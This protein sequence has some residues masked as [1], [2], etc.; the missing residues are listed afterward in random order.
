MAFQRQEM[1]NQIQQEH[2]SAWGKLKLGLGGNLSQ[3]ALPIAVFEQKTKRDAGIALVETKVEHLVEHLVR[4]IKADIGVKSRHL[5][6]HT[7]R[8]L[9]QTMAGEVSQNIPEATKTALL[10][11]RQYIDSLS[12]QYVA[13]LQ[14]KVA[15]L[16]DEVN[17]KQ[18]EAT[19]LMHS[20]SLAGRLGKQLKTKIQARVQEVQAMQSALAAQKATIETI[21]GNVGEYVHRSYRAFDDPEWALKVPDTVLNK[22]REHVQ[23]RY[24]AQGLT[25]A[26]ANK[27]TEVVLQE[28]LKH[29]TAYESMQGLIH[30][31]KLGA[32][33][34]SVLMHRKKIA[35]PIRD[36]LGEYVDPRVAFA[37]TAT[38]M[39]RLIFNHSFL[40]RVKDAGMGQ[41]LWTEAEKPPE[42]TVK[43][44]ADKSEVY[45][46]LN[47]LWTTPE[48]NQAF[49][50]AL[51]KEQ[52]ANL[53]Q[54]IFQ[55]I[56]MIKSDQASLFSATY[57]QFIISVT[58]TA[59]AWRLF[60][61]IHW[62]PNVDWATT[63]LHCLGITSVGGLILFLP[64]PKIE[65]SEENERNLAT[66]GGIEG[67]GLIKKNRVKW[68]LSPWLFP[69]LLIF[70]VGLHTGFEYM[71]KTEK[72][73]MVFADSKSGL[74][75]W[76]GRNGG[77]SCD[78]SIIREFKKRGTIH[79]GNRWEAERDGFRPAYECPN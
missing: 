78:E 15:Q 30:E 3:G 65:L 50:D 61:P 26:E 24:T 31:S 56:G 34:L 43:I 70:G 55:L 41:F 9:S 74:Y 40:D 59:I 47:G 25:A 49:K 23:E 19:R 52:M 63:I 69:L 51:G 22:A 4:S 73:H 35:Q 18:R 76:Y 54:S 11:M 57:F 28:I 20:E 1:N 17:R 8:L 67:L 68:L 71:E 58:L 75:V 36:L 53:Y 79:Y 5:E 38:K 45:S 42:A 64:I 37:K 72:Y 39:G 12:A 27:R 62:G 48:T 16:G 77:N 66:L 6:E 13:I 46:P 10:G 2:K 60:Y 7:K 44:A 14:K 21:L 29:G 32:K 33:D